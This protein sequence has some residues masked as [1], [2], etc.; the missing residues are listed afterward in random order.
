MRDVIKSHFCSTF[1]RM[2]EHTLKLAQK[3]AKEAVLT[4]EEETTSEA[5]D[6][7]PLPLRSNAA[8]KLEEKVKGFR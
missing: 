4:D 2:E 1:K 6:G 8:S 5:R 3:L 7:N